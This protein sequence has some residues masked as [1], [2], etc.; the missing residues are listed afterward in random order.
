MRLGVNLIYLIC[1]KSTK[2]NNGTAQDDFSGN[3]V[4]FNIYK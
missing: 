4:V 1:V 3:D 2:N